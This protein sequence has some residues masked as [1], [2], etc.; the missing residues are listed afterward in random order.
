MPTGSLPSPPVSPFRRAHWSRRRRW[1]S[2]LIFWAVTL[3]VA[4]LSGRLVSARIGETSQP[5]G[6]TIAVVVAVRPLL[7]G[8]LVQADDVVIKQL[9]VSFVSAQPIRETRL[10]I[11][12]R[13]DRPISAGSPIDSAFVAYGSTSSVAARVGPGRRG[14]VVE[15]NGA[16]LPVAPG[17]RVDVLVSR[18]GDGETELAVANAMVVERIEQAV[19]LSVETEQVDDLARGLARGRPVLALRGG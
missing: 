9:P 6:P 16:P 14:V 19:L 15:L 1:I 12:K 10:V 7:A 17:D 18:D 5:F 4:V 3:L 2:P 8:D 11:D 13:I